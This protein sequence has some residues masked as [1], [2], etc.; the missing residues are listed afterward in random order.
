[1]NRQY[2]YLVAGL[3]DLL[4]EDKK[5]AV[6]TVEYRN[7]LSEHLGSEEMSWIHLLFW[8]VDNRNILNQLNA[9]EEQFLSGGNL[10]SIQLDELFAAQKSDSLESLDF[11]IPQYLIE[12]IEAFKTET[13][14]YPGKSWE[15]QLTEHY[16]TY[17]LSARNSFVSNWF[18]YERDVSN[19]L[20]A[21]NCRNS[22]L[23]IDMQLVG[24]DDLVDK[25]T[26]SSA[27]DFGLSD[28]LNNADKL[29]KALEE[30]DLLE[31][32]KKI[33]LLR[34]NTIEDESFF[35][36][37][38][39]EKLFTFLIKLSIAE[40]WIALDRNTG[41]KLFEELLKSLE[42]SYE[43]PGEFSLK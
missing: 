31:Q 3:P 13:P 34:W 30:P 12:Y 43:F 20:T 17:A 4:F 42:N 35:H 5:L 40:R 14:L 38:S 36:Y 16:Y 25:L 41:L 23:P 10:S 26:R 22:K 24:N 39:I 6:S 18:K 37:F 1:M 11:S 2:Y 8:Q 27:R 9:K 19:L 7:Y 29:L 28:E 32:E 15:L 33:D 21:Y